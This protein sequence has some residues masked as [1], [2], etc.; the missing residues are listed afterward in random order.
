M[1]GCTGCRT[2]QGA[3]A[4]PGQ[5]PVPSWGTLGEFQHLHNPI[6]RVIQQVTKDTRVSF[7]QALWFQV[8][9]PL[10]NEKA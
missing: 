9:Q 10:T 5:S 7:P 2:S 1:G 3:A 4:C 8:K 6:S